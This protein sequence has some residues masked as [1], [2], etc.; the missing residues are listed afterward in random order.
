M[1][2]AEGVIS[3]LPRYGTLLHRQKNFLRAEIYIKNSLGP[4]VQG[5]GTYNNKQVTSLS[6]R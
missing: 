4:C 6:E 1:A 2:S 5:V 3:M